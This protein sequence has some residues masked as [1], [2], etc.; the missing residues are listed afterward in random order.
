[1]HAPTPRAETQILVDEESC[2]RRSHVDVGLNVLQMQANA[3][4]RESQ[5]A[6]FRGHI[7]VLRPLGGRLYWARL[8]LQRVFKPSHFVSSLV[9]SLHPC[10]EEFN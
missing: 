8:S 4:D 3:E 7:D 2:L 1:M 6:I 5:A 10:Q 9:A